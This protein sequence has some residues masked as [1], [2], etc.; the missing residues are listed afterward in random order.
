MALIKN[1]NSASVSRDAIVLDLADLQKY[2]SQLVVQARAKADQILAEANAERA[3]IV[4]GAAEEGRAEGHAAGL[5]EGRREGHEAAMTS[6]TI[7]SRAGFEAVQAGWTAGLEAFSGAREAMLLSA[8]REVLALGVEIARRVTK[9]VITIDPGVVVE[10]I[11]AVLAVVVRPTELVVRINPEDQAVA[12][13]AMPELL[14]RF[15]S[16][17]H[18]ELA[19]DRTL[20]RGSCVAA[21]RGDAG[22]LEGGSI[23]ASIGTQL[24]RIIEAL[25]PDRS[26]DLRGEGGS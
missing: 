1:A 16:V 26:K 19:E 6:V 9:R 18:V 13:A 12:L 8:E 7:E 11:R 22:G 4:A 24:D 15:P 5:E 17:R 25:C 3:R 2:A 23:D 20:A 14:A 21:M 10:Q